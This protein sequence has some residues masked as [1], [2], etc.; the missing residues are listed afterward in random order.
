MIFN[1][2]LQKPLADHCIFD[3]LFRSNKIKCIYLK[4][5]LIHTRH[6]ANWLPFNLKPHGNT[7]YAKIASA[8]LYFI[9]RF[10]VI[11]TNYNTNQKI[12]AV[13]T[14]NWF[15]AASQMYWLS[16]TTSV[17]NLLFIFIWPT[18]FK[19]CEKIMCENY[20]W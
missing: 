9:C 1:G 10:S 6:V 5:K 8:I 13:S 3:C 2:K 14:K 15:Q 19:R 20:V 12:S 17:A 11:S 18:I 16:V 7:Y 4:Q